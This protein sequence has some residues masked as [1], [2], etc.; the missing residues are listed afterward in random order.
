MSVVNGAGTSGM[1]RPETIADRVRT[2]RNP[3]RRLPSGERSVCGT[4]PCAYDRRRRK[5]IEPNICGNPRKTVMFDRPPELFVR[6]RTTQ[7]SAR[8]CERDES[9]PY[10]PTQGAVGIEVAKYSLIFSQFREWQRYSR[11]RAVSGSRRPGRAV[12]HSRPDNWRLSR[13]AWSYEP[14]P[15]AWGCA[16]S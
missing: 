5:I 15:F 4:D 11:S 13:T 16:F 3:S 12:L 6:H 1:S 10:V 8:S 2:V 7:V 14:R 9:I